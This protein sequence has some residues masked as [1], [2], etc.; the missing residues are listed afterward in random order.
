M[1][2]LLTIA[3]PPLKHIGAC[4]ADSFYSISA[5]PAIPSAH[6]LFSDMA[7]YTG[8]VGDIPCVEVV[9]EAEVV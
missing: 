9:E 7:D 8:R 4:D 5:I 3:H 1:R 2:I 6:C